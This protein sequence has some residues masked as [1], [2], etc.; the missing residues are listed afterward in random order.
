[1]LENASNAVCA[2]TTVRV[3][4][5][6][7]LSVDSHQVRGEMIRTI[8]GSVLSTAKHEISKT[9]MAMYSE[10]DGFGN[11][12]GVPGQTPKLSNL[13]RIDP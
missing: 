13:E 1:M 10:R 3:K 5:A 2:A 6:G 8:H 7:P 11:W 12:R 9:L 4:Q